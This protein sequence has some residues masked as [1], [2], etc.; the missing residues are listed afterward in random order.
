MSI[1][2][3]NSLESTNTTA[4]EMAISGAGHGTAIIAECQTAGRGRYGRA[5]YSPSGGLYMSLILHPERINFDTP[6]LVT[7]F[8]AVS[9]C[10]A[11]EF[12]CDKKPKI[13]WVNDIFI[14]E[15]KICGILTEAVTYKNSEMK[16]IVGIGI[17]FSPTNFPDEIKSIAG[18]LFE[19][20]NPPIKKNH[21]AEEI[22]KRISEHQFG[23]E[24]MLKKYRS[25][26]LFLGEKITV[27]DSQ[28]KYEA[29][30]I[31]IDEEGRLIIKR[32]G[33]TESLISGE[34]SIL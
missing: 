21:L 1:H 22:I 31:D 23:S 32:N 17:N 16:I 7:A 33:K 18:T 10:E 13:K 26:M 2:I 19:E 5:F 11:I 15:K 3:F 25:R 34:V 12:L 24:E 27:S 6:T 4:K 29:T 9:V 28:G 20:E 8:S 30:A 14:C